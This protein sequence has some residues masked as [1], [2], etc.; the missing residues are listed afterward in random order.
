[1]QMETYPFS[2]GGFSDKPAY[3]N[4]V[5]AD[6]SEG[7]EEIALTYGD[8]DGDGA[9]DVAVG[10]RSSSLTIFTHS[11]DGDLAS[12]AWKTIDVHTFGIARTADLDASGKDDII[13]Y[14]PRGK[15]PKDIEVIRF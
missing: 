12:R 11:A 3:T 5:T 9:K 13:I 7:R 6:V 8:F 1:M 14:H 10:A 4:N 2:N 15:F